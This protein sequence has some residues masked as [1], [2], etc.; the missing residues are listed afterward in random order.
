MPVVLS[1]VTL[2]K[3]DTESIAQHLKVRH[4][5]RA[6]LDDLKANFAIYLPSGDLMIGACALEPGLH[7]RYSQHLP[8]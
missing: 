1:A 7:D 5:R 3:S 6:F 2:A 4:R 8:L